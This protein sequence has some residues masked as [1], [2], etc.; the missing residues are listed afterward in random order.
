MLLQTSNLAGFSREIRFERTQTELTSS[1]Q[2]LHAD[3][4]T[5]IGAL[6]GKR[7]GVR[8]VKGLS[9]RPLRAFL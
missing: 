3:R 7:V 6:R 5:G 8:K 9:L 2:I 4:R 1:R